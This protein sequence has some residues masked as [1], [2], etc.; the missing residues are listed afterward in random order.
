MTDGI[1]LVCGVVVIIDYFWDL[2]V[3]DWGMMWTLNRVTSR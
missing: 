3:L 2:R 1:I